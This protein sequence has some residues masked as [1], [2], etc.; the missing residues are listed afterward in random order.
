MPG[1]YWFRPPTASSHTHLF[2]CGSDSLGITSRACFPLALVLRMCCPVESLDY[3]KASSHHE[4]HCMSACSR[5]RCLTII[6]DDVTVFVFPWRNTDETTPLPPFPLVKVREFVVLPIVVAIC[7]A[8]VGVVPRL[9]ILFWFFLVPACRSPPSPSDGPRWRLGP[10]F[11]GPSL[12]VSLLPA[13]A[14]LPCLCAW[15]VCCALF[16]LLIMSHGNKGL[17][18][19]W[20]S[21]P[22][23][24]VSCVV[25]VLCAPSLRYS[26]LYDPCPLLGLR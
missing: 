5:T 15:S 19:V 18:P 2:S 24:H 11:T 8:T 20:G 17:G 1:P 4:A 16:P 12:W 10:G 23:H 13:T 14:W 7:R 25:G 3:T 26:S 21:F 6:G 22:L 9:L